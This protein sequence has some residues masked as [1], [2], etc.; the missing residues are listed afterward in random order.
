MS[1]AETCVVACAEAWRGDG[2]VLAGSAGVIPG[3]GA[4]LAQLTF[5]RELLVTDGE[6]TLLRDGRVEGWLPYR[7]VFAIVAAG[8]RHV[9]MGASQLDRFGNQN[10][11]CVGPWERPASQLLCVRG[12]P[13]NTVNHPVSYW[14]PRHSPRVFVERVDMVSGVG[15]D[16]GAHEIRLVVTNLAVLDFATPDRSMRL[17]SV[18]PG[19]T[20]D[21]VIAA[22]GFELTVP[23]QVPETREPTAD[24]QRLIRERL[25]PDGRRER[26]VR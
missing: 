18:H 15:H 2:A 26:E 17:R 19:V 23:D 14:V 7:Q 11:S 21:E 13:G 1:R 24:E 22:T 12:A 6:A 3:L 5:A 25:D 20:V 9:M 8:T 4:R 16:R 10:I